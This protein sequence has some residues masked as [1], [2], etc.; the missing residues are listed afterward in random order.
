ME[1]SVRDLKRH[2]SED[3]RRARA[4]EEIVVTSHGQPV[5]RLMGVHASGSAP[6]MDAVAR[7]R[8]Q[9]WVRPGNGQPVSGSGS[10]AA[11]PAGT[12]NEVIH[13]CRSE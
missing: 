13:W 1:V 10:P 5:D 6:E 3:L 4:G 12:T 11:V 7:L 9:S 2:L 8:T